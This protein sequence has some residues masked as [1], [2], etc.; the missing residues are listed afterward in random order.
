MQF[1]PDPPLFGVPFKVVEDADLEGG[2]AGVQVVEIF[3][4]HHLLGGLTVLLGYPEFGIKTS[5]N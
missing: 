2:Q 4:L 1:L 5:K 3:H